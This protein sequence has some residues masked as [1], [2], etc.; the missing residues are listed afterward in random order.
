MTPNRPLIPGRAG[1]LLAELGDRAVCR[2]LYDEVGAPVYH[3]LAGQDTHEV[4]ELLTLV[5]TVPGP[6]L[7]LA[8]GS[9]RL[10]MPLLASGRDVTAL[11]LSGSMLKLLSAR[12]AEAPEALRNRC[13]PVRADMSDFALGREF[14]VIVLGTTSVSLLD[15]PGRKGLYRSVRAHL[16]P[17]GRFLLSTVDLTADEQA[18]TET[19]V[20]FTAD[21]GRSHRVFEYWTPGAEARTVTVFPAVTGAG[22]VDVCTTTIRVLSA[23]QLEEELRRSG[24][25]VCSRRLLPDVGARHHSV[26]IE[27]EVTA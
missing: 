25:A 15:A 27:A 22:Q 13:T 10:T 1:A 5:R 21:S 11:E 16:A 6:V 9:G 24:F 14:G 20:E 17:G 2:D 12:L 26:L 8:A 18:P 23:G 7:D 3:D 4:R 19:E